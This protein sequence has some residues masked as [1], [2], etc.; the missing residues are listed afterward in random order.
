MLK[1]LNQIATSPRILSLYFFVNEL[2]ESH[3]RAYPGRRF[4]FVNQINPAT[5]IHSNLVGPLLSDIFTILLNA[6]PDQVITISAKGE[7]DALRLSGN[8]TTSLS[9]LPRGTVAA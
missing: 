5:I 4:Q 9:E 6:S 2:L 3:H 1:T 7:G 8:N